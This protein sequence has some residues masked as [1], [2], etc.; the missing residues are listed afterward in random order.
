MFP[1]RRMQ[2]GLYLLP[3]TNIKSKWIKDLNI[4][5]VIPNL[6]EEKV[7]SSLECTG[8]GDN[9]RNVI[10]V[11]WTLKLTINGTFWNWKACKVKDTVNKIQ[12]QP[13]EWEKSFTNPI[14]DRS[15]KIYKELKK[16]D[17]KIPNNPVKKW[18]TDL[19]KILNRRISNGQKTLK[20]MFN[21]LCHQGNVN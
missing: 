4:N 17:I 9:F 16:L 11:A 1:C 20:K 15:S 12:W 21:I 6:I 3:C 7:G 19:N 18:G 13:T 5:P 10:P 14:S 2:R 8:T